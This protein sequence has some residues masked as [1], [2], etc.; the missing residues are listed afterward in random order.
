L[1]ANTKLTVVAETFA[2]VATCWSVARLLCRSKDFLIIDAQAFEQV[3]Q[4]LEHLITP[5]EGSQDIRKKIQK[6]RS[7][8]PLR[9]QGSF[10]MFTGGE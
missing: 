8:S 5:P 4:T 3:A 2:N 6:L 9:G 1:P 7:E 10:G